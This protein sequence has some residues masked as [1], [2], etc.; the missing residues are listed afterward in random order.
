MADNNAFEQ[1]R[2]ENEAKFESHNKAVK[3]N[4]E[5]RKDFWS[6]L[7]Q[8]IELYVPRIFT[9]LLGIKEKERN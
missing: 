8:I 2:Q 9:T 6:L 5:G 4:V 7:G 1:L 3:K